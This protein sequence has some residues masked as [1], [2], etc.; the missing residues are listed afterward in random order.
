MPM[1]LESFLKMAIIGLGGLETH[2]KQENAMDNCFNNLHILNPTRKHI[3]SK[4]EHLK[5][6]TNGICE[7]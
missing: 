7:M 6:L 3:K 4:F 5:P 2:S 1:D